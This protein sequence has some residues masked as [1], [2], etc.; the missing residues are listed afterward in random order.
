MV[1][2]HIAYLLQLC[3]RVFHLLL[4][5]AL[6]ALLLGAL[7][8]L[9]GATEV[10]QAIH[11]IMLSPVLYFAWLI[12]FLSCSAIE[13]QI[14]ACGYKKPARL[15]YEYSDTSLARIDIVLLATYYQNFFRTWSFPLCTALLRIPYL[16]ELVLLSYAPSVSIGRDVII[17]GYIY[18]PDLVQIGDGAVLGGA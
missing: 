8:F 13:I 5:P 12:F 16:R 7:L 15:V 10:L 18:D 11:W 1:T 17:F 14:L 3:I 2:N 4:A 6:G 9:S